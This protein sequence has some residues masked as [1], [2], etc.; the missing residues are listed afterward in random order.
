MIT[1]KNFFTANDELFMNML[2]KVAEKT[3]S[4]A[5]CSQV[6]VALQAFMQKPNRV[7]RASLQ[8]M[9]KSLQAVSVSTDFAVLTT[10]AFNVTVEEDNF[11]M[12]WE[13]SFQDVP[14][15]G[16]SD[17][18]EIGNIKNGIT[19]KKVLEGERIEVLTMT[20]TKQNIYVDYYGGA[21]GFTDKAIRFRKLA[22]MLD[23]ARAFRN[24]FYANK[25]DNHYLLLATAA[26]LNVITW[27]GVGGTQVQ[28]DV[29]TINEGAFQIGNVNKDKGYGDMANAGLILYANPSDRARIEA[30]FVLTSN[31]LTVAA[32]A[33]GANSPGASVTTQPIQRVY[34]YNANIV[35]R[36]PLLVLPG[37]K[38]QKN[39]AMAP[40]TFT[41]PKD[42]LTLNEVQ[43]VWSI[44]GAGMG[45]TDQAYELELE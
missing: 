41:Q 5:E 15:D 16:T 3:A 43:S 8:A 20:G 34:T 42:I 37:R 28:R 10:N 35:A 11:D 14:R 12:G 30:A 22:Q 36:H 33:I 9:K 39:E 7:M 45:D 19:F 1:N 4:P 24:K 17:F 13:L 18:W 29:A 32:G 25:A 21:L 6:N 40:T 27:Q 23:Q 31:Y 44:Y 26:A 38:S 2:L